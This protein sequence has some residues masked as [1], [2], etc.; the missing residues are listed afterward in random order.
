MPETGV[1]VPLD[2]EFPWDGGPGQWHWNCRC[3]GAP[4]FN[5]P[6]LDDLEG[7]TREAKGGPVSA[8]TTYD[9]WLRS[10]SPEVQD[11]VLG[12]GRGAWYRAH[13]DETLTSAWR[14]RFGGQ[15]I[16]PLSRAE[17]GG[18]P[19]ARA[20][21]RIT[22]ED[23]AFWGGRAP[24]HEEIDRWLAEQPPG[25]YG[26]AVAEIKPRM[27][28]LLDQLD[29]APTKEA[30]LGLLE[31]HDKLVQEYSR[32]LEGS[33]SEQYAADDLLRRRLDAGLL[34]GKPERRGERVAGE[35]FF[36][37][38]VRAVSPPRT[39]EESSFDGEVK[40]AMAWL[41]SRWGGEDPVEVPV[42]R[43][44]YRMEPGRA[45]YEEG[46]RTMK[47]DPKND[48]GVILHETGHWLENRV[49][50]LWG[51][52]VDFLR[53]RAGEE[54]SSRIYEHDPD[55]HEFG[56]K[57]EFFTHYVGKWYGYSIGEKG[58]ADVIRNWET[59]ETRPRPKSREHFYAT[60]V[61]S[62]GIEAMW[63]DPLEFYRRDREHFALIWRL[64][65]G[66][67]FGS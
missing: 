51:E 5:D 24:T 49:P 17:A 26:R 10:Q 52:S 37:D 31:E 13:P 1:L 64:L 21:R 25:P 66:D 48:R 62:M 12:K 29:T 41:D 61:V 11:K 50:G 35:R 40:Q 14:Q 54:P 20:E 23:I 42:D 63:R 44:S 9:R 43:L 60:E 8:G 59:G 57:D 19:I 46:S 65:R 27:K 15:P 39:A 4:W 16:E 38:S 2:H 18:D 22:P 28:A 58:R 7:G 45:H 47:L 32:L 34:S 56:W 30:R 55:K 53:R 67:R 3:G 36:A 6:I 33:I